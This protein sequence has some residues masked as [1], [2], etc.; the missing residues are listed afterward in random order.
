MARPSQNLTARLTIRLKPEELAQLDRDAA[1]AAT[2]RATIARAHLLNAPMP[3]KVR[4]TSNAD[5][6]ALARIL[7][8]LGRIGNNLNQLA[9][10]ANTVGDLRALRGLEMMR[11]ELSLLRDQVRKAL[12]P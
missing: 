5:E 1:R 12:N 8:Q 3:K 4:R 10:I 7:A 6:Q 2:D 9:R 11:D